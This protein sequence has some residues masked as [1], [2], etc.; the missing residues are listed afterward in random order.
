M[1]KK[2]FC[3]VV[4]CLFCVSL[5]FGDQITDF[6]DK[7][8][9]QKSQ[10]KTMINEDGLSIIM[11]FDNSWFCGFL[12]KDSDGVLYVYKEHPVKDTSMNIYKEVLSK[13]PVD[14]REVESLINKAVS[15]NDYI[16]SNGYRLLS[17]E[18][19]KMLVRTPKKNWY[20]LRLY[21]EDR[22]LLF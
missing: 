6:I 18:Y 16:D 12:C 15:T 5:I 17:L 4:F 7:T 1:I 9:K 10:I 2:C 11:P 14:V 13:S 20:L 3:G 8:E 22:S 21:D 19:R